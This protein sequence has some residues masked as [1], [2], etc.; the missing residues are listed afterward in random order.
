MLIF[1]MDNKKKS[2]EYKC[3]GLRTGTV[4]SCLVLLDLGE[5]GWGWLSSCPWSAVEK[6]DHT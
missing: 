2:G 5:P 1:Y 3:D 6:S 4:K